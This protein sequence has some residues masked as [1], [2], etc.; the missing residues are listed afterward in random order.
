MRRPQGSWYDNKRKDKLPAYILK[1]D[2]ALNYFVSSIYLQK[3]KDRGAILEEEDA[4]WM[5]I[6]TADSQ[7]PGKQPRRLVKLNLEIGMYRLSARFMVFDLADY[8][9]ILGK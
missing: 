2:G 9:I 5:K 8:D 6:R 3:L 4:E 1:N 7:N